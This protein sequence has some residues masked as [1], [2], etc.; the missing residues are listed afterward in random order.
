MNILVDNN[1]ANKYMTEIELSMKQI[2]IIRS[3][4]PTR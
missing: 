3:I 4:N 1:I 2:W